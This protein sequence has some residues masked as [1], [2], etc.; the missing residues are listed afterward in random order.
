LTLSDKV[1]Q[2]SLVL[3]PSEHLLTFKHSVI[4]LIV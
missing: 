4:R 1:N 3:I 2:A